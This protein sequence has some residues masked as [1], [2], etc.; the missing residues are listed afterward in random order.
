M[1]SHEAAGR[2]RPSS[3]AGDG[4]PYVRKQTRPS[5]LPLLLTGTQPSRGEA[6]TP[7]SQSSLL[8]TGDRRWPQ[9][10]P[11]GSS[12]V[13]L[14]QAGGLCAAIH[15]HSQR[16]KQPGVTLPRHSNRSFVLD[17]GPRALVSVEELRLLAPPLARALE[18]ASGSAL[19]YR[20]RRVDEP[21]TRRPSPS[22]VP[23]RS[24]ASAPRDSA[25][26]T[27]GGAARM[28]LSPHRR[29]QPSPD[30]PIARRTR[31]PSDLRGGIP[32]SKVVPRGSREDTGGEDARMLAECAR[33]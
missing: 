1:L 19:G 33:L 26:I 2:G 3:W 21:W 28:L 24:R 12:S 30:Q 31:V 4:Y 9:A 20:Q 5:L 8:W 29:A 14:R 16:S 13:P 11:R 15:D 32:S 10:P 25:S 6:S 18:L 23:H 22:R 27:R 17:V 7:P